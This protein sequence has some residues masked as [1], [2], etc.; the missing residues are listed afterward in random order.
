MTEPLV[1]VVIATYNHEKILSQAI[2]SILE[3][4][5]DFAFEVIINDDA[6]TDGTATVVK[7]YAEKYPDI[8]RPIY[9]SI[10]QCS[11]GYK[12]MPTFLFP[13][14]RGKYI[15]ICEG[16]DYWTDPD[17]LQKQVSFLEN[18]PDYS[19]SAH[20]SMKVYD[21]GTQELFKKRVKPVIHLSDLL[22]TRIFH[23]ASFVF[24]T[25]LIRKYP[26]APINMHSYDRLLFMLMAANGPIRYF[27]DCMCVYRLHAGGLSARG[28]YA[29][30][31]KDFNAIPYM[32][33]NIPH[34]PRYRYLAFLHRICF[35]YPRDKMSVGLI[36]K[37]YFA[38]VL[39]SFSYFPINIWVI[40]KNTPR[41][42]HRIFNRSK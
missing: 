29:K 39:Y 24:R 26:P 9:Q 28:T 17:K 31:A 36:L 1:S 16:D 4:K 33:E 22:E 34:F 10:N 27:D 38:F 2:E 20:Q 35:V 32:V 6:S 41:M 19:A 42:F 3:Q 12:I 23:T 11:I 37:H 30:I 15:A 5:T 18:N 40:I 25:Q 8:I 7:D 13:E 21:D 14:A